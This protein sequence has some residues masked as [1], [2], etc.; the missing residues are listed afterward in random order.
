MLQCC[1]ILVQDRLLLSY[2]IISIVMTETISCIYL[3][4]NPLWRW[5]CI[6]YRTPPLPSPSPALQGRL[7]LANAGNL[8][9]LIRHRY[10]PL[11]KLGKDRTSKP[12]PSPFTQS[13]VFG[14]SLFFPRFFS[15]STDVR[16]LQ[17]MISVTT[18]RPAGLWLNPADTRGPEGAGHV[19]NRQKL[20]TIDSAEEDK[21]A[22]TQWKPLYTLHGPW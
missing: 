5:V 18:M 12:H 8:P 11:W 20:W 19:R 9:V 10:N 6:A 1:H 7:W 4:Y 2:W 15:R 17:R 22:S 16:A 3:S 21:C 13:P 14:P